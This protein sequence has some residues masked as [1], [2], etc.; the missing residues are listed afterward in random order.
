M[1]LGISG[2]EGSFANT[3]QPV[4]RGNGDAAVFGRQSLFDLSQCVIA[5]EEMRR[6]AHRDIRLSKDFAG[7]SQTARGG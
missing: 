3:T 7:K 4:E 2:G 5:A 1:A 6:H